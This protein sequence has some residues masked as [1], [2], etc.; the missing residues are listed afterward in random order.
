MISRILAAAVLAGA[1]VGL[2]LYSQHRPGRYRVSGFVEADEIRIGSRVGGRVAEVLCAEGDSVAEGATLLRLEGFD[3][4]ARA[5]EAEAN[6]AARE[7]ELAQLRHGNR[8]EEIAMAQARADRLQAQLQLLIDGPR[9]EEILAAEARRDLAEAQV[10][11]ARSSYDRVAKLF[12]R[13]GGTVTQEEVDRAMEEL[14]VAEHFLRVREQER[15]IQRKGSRAEQIAAATAE[16]E[17]AKQAL[18]MSKAGYRSEEIGRAEAAV[19]AAKAAQA[20]V[21]AQRDELLIR[22]PCH[23]TVEALD[24]QPGDLVP[25]GAPVLSLLD[26]TRF[27]VRAYVPEN[28]LDLK[29]G[30]EVRVTIDSFTNE[31]FSGTVTYVARQAEFTPNNV[32]TPEERSKQVFRIKVTLQQGLKQLRPGMAADVWLPDEGQAKREAV[33]GDLK[34]T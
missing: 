1:L 10:K 26:A 30:Q 32:Q 21:Q 20:V 34:S 8:S 18:A 5:A 2:L 11:R 16:L 15:Q 33:G 25:A 29:P 19:A 4:D 14:Q 24:L 13:G 9:E 28:R 3:L 6:L 17:E 27:W 31:E 23:A 22:A 12:A 7:A